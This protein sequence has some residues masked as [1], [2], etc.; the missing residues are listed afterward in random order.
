MKRLGFT[1]FCAL[2]FLGLM[3][4]PLSV[5]E[6]EG[7]SANGIFQISIENG[8]SQ[9]V[10]FEARVA[11][12]GNTTGEITF[13]DTGAVVSTPKSTEDSEVDS[14]L[15]SFYAKATC[16]CLVVQGVEAAMSGTVTE[17]SRKNLVGRRVVLVV[18][19]GD[20]LTPPLRDKLTFGFYNVP[21]NVMGATD[22][23]RPE[24]QG[25]PTW[26]A[27]DAERSDDTGVILKKDQEV[28]CTSFPISSFNFLGAKQG[29][30]KIQVTR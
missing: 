18:Q 27:T 17:S 26:V 7:V 8:Q 11:K 16:D 29:K 20:S 13:R 1:S 12:D 23:E 6:G 21:Q 15:P 3:M 2:F 4:P 5:A 22:A 24:E 9:E 19:D 28:T 25:S 14:A 10:Q 30:G